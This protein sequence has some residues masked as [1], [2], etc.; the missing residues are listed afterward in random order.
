MTQSVHVYLN[1]SNWRFD[2][3]DL[4]EKKSLNQGE[5]VFAFRDPFSHSVC[6]K[7][8]LKRDMKND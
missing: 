6:V 5:K 8:Q 7:F 3:F 2:N 1:H 4:E